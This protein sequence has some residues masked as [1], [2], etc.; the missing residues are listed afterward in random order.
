MQPKSSAF[1]RYGLAILT[2][3]LALAIKLVFLQFKVTFPLSC[4]FLAAIAI[5]VWFA[6][7]LSGIL[8]VVFSSIAFGDIVVPY[9]VRLL[10]GAQAASLSDS[11]IT[12][13]PYLVY[14]GL[15]A[16]LM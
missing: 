10:G 7:S 16:L 6:G 5:T 3:G 13:L 4:S 15:V 14:F 2:V 11:I 12:T 8:V 9:Q 1:Y